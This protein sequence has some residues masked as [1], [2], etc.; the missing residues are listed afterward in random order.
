MTDKDRI[1]QETINL[2]LTTPRLRLNQMDVMMEK[3]NHLTGFNVT[4]LEQVVANERVYQKQRE[5]QMML[6]PVSQFEIASAIIGYRKTLLLFEAII[7]LLKQL[8]DIAAKSGCFDTT[9][10]EMII[11]KTKHYETPNQG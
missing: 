3:L 11:R 6:Q 1:Q 10:V 5:T 9:Q 8:S 4:I 2:L 7:P